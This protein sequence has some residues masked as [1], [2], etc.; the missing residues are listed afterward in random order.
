MDSES[1]EIVNIY[2]DFRDRIAQKVYTEWEFESHCFGLV[3]VKM[4]Q[5]SFN[6][7]KA[8]GLL[9]PDLYYESA[10]SLLRNLWETSLDLHWVAQDPDNRSKLF[11]NFTMVEYR[12]NLAASDQQKYDNAAD[13]Y[14]KDFQF[15]DKNGKKRFYRK[16]S[17]LKPVDV[18]K[19][20]GKDWE[21]EYNRIYKLS[22]AYIHGSP[23]IILFP[24]YIMQEG[25]E[26]S[27]DIDGERTTKTA[28][29]AIAIMAKLYILFCSQVGLDDSEYL[30]DLENKVS[31]KTAF[32]AL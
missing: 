1:L 20:L 12:K 5:H 25:Q 4:F 3:L 7:Y 11:L 9:L 16:F 19:K 17:N 10:A 30:A 21:I 13:R 31:L 2:N 24:I 27:F 15:T 14:L 28:I 22:C 29:W 23:G 6:L 32:Q 26:M 8:I 18:A